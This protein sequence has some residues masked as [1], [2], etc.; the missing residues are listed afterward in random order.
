VSNRRIVVEAAFGRTF[1]DTILSGDWEPLTRP[2]GVTRAKAATWTIGRE[3][4]FEDFPPGTATILL[5]DRDRQLDPDNPASDYAGALLPLT[6]VRIRSQNVDTLA[7]ENEFYGY[8]QNGWQRILAPKETG[9]CQIDLI[10]LLGVLGGRKLPDVLDD[11]IMTLDPAGYWV[12]DSNE[13]EVV[14][15]A[16]T[17]DGRLIG[18]VSTGGVPVLEG[19]RP[20]VDF[21]PGNEFTAEAGE[22]V[23][24]A[25]VQI[26]R[27]PIVSSPLNITWVATFQARRRAHTTT[28]ARVVVAH[29][30][31][32]GSGK[33]TGAFAY[34]T[35]AN[36]LRYARVVN[37][38]GLTYEVTNPIVGASHVFFGQSGGIAVDTATLTTTTV[39]GTALH[40][41]GVNIGGGPGIAA[42]QHWDG[43]IGM[44]A[45]FSR[46]LTLTERQSILTASRR[47]S[48]EKTGAAIDWALDQL[49]VPSAMRSI[50]DGTVTLPPVLTHE[51]DALEFMREV[52]ATEGGSLYVDHRGGGTLRFTNRYYRYLTSTSTASQATFS[53]DP[54]AVNVIRYPPEGLD[55][56]PNGLDGIINEVTATWGGDGEVIER[57]DSSIAAYGPRT[58]QI[59]TVGPRA[60]AQS[61][62]EWL[63]VRYKDPRSRILGV[64]ASRRTTYSRDDRVQAL[65]INNRVTVRVQPLRSGTP[66]AVDQ[67]VEGITN[68]V[69]DVTWETSFRFGQVPNFVPWIW[70][71]SAWGTTAVWG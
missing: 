66:T 13:E 54:D 46:A 33:D 51:R 59:D 8:V 64:A 58:R 30:D 47:L 49:G 50:D 34:L 70:G 31:G 60:L 2:N 48:G 9:D 43:W 41:V 61:A 3:D 5:W 17:N 27:S 62:A 16:G 11:A 57:D 19:D 37:G 44:A 71:T 1:T 40:P 53:D 10:D 68:T 4:E 15:R 6:P 36:R 7:Y 39:V 28:N 38:A 29:T 26:T 42:V 14:D 45:L 55:I 12:L 63:I 21:T 20:S 23:L 18:S 52:T 35:S 65:A 69:T 56:A 67:Y 25:R 22:E 24:P 32:N